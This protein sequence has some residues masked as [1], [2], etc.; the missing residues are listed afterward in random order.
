MSGSNKAEIRK[1][2]VYM[3][4]AITEAPEA[5]R[6]WLKQ[7][8]EALRKQGFDVFVPHEYQELA[9]TPEEKILQL[10]VDKLE[11]ADFMVASLM[12][13]STG[14]GIELALFDGPVVGLVHTKTE[15]SPFVRQ[16]LEVIGNRVVRVD[17]IE[18]AV[19]AICGRDQGDD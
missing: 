7:L 9:E 16:F 11:W 18:E 14:V 17:S 15:L 19:D 4:G 13:P 1:L 5:M 3:S 10:D 6:V 8:G 2:R 12:T